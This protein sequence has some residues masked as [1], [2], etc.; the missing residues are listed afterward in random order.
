MTQGKVLL[1][2]KQDRFSAEAAEIAREALGSRLTVFTGQVGDPYPDLSFPTGRDTLIS[3]LSPWIVRQEDLDRA[4]TAINFHPASV[5]YPG[6]GC[7]NFALYDE[8]AEFGAVCHH[9]L[10]KVDTGRIVDERRFPLHPDDS[11]ETLKLRTMETMV[12]MF[13]DLV[14]IIARGEPLPE[15]PVHWTR[16]PYTRKQLHALK[17][18]TPDMDE[19]EVARRVRAVTYPGYPGAVLHRPDGTTYEFPVPDRPPIA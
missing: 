19:A 6:I 2:S 5:D 11:V 3:F 17:V 7:Y 8:A 14:P 12:A 15:A 18:I 1:L 10:A 13:R 4:G 9:M 16:G